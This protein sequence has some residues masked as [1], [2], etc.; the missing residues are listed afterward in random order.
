M[1]WVDGASAV[2]TAAAI[3]KT[4]TDE[5]HFIDISQTFHHNS[6]PCFGR[7]KL[8]EVPQTRPLPPSVERDMDLTRFTGPSA[9]G[10]AYQHMMLRDAHAPGSV[11]RVLASS[12]VRLSEE[13]AE[14]LYD[15]FTSLGLGY[16]RGNR[17]QIEAILDS[18]FPGDSGHEERL[19]AIVE[20]TR[21]LGDRAEKDLW[22]MR[23]GGTE[24]E[25]IERGSD[26][27]SDVARVACILC[28]VA[29][30]PCRIVNLFDLDHAY[31]GHV[32]VEAH[33]A[34][35]WGALDSSTGVAY[36]A[37]DGLSASVWDLMRDPALV[38]VH[39]ENPRAF[40]STPGQFRAAGITNY[41]VWEKRHYDY[42]VTAINDY[43]FSILSM[44]DKGW[45]GGLRWLHGEDGEI[46]KQRI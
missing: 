11:D 9:F 4:Q 44:S 12:M 25:I 26:W 17:P 18:I 7:L 19:A 15:P 2:A 27:C 10:P 37:S 21:A 13:T 20:F 41:A 38:E 3:A 35:R 30:F 14:Y 32:I 40:Y 39:R 24:E 45:P 34:G 36:L 6:G 42:T 43:Y 33:R 5:K 22:K 46:G 23:L 16:D 29:G 1:G 31:S 28:Q 8:Q